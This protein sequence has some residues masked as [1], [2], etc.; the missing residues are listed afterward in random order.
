MKNII[1]IFRKSLPAVPQIS[2]AVH[3]YID[4]CLHQILLMYILPE[5]MVF[6]GDT[7]M[8]PGGHCTIKWDEK[9]RRTCA[10]EYLDCVKQRLVSEFSDTLQIVK[11]V[12]QCC[13][14]AHL[15]VMLNAL[16]AS[17]VILG[18]DTA[19]EGLSALL[20]ESIDDYLLTKLRVPVVRVPGEGGVCG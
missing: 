17:L 18:P 8:L 7:R 4:P 6:L 10:K 1:F 12:H 16:N 11:I 2:W 19:K 13:S 3:E 15:D 14:N 5:R 20:H 9:K